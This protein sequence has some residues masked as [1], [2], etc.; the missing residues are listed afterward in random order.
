MATYPFIEII[1][2]NSGLEERRKSPF[3]VFGKDL[4]EDGSA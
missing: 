3:A 1:A 4:P 2:I